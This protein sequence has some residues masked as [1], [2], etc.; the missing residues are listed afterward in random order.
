MDVL[1]TAG[2]LSYVL[3]SGA[4]NVSDPGHVA[5]NDY[6]ASTNNVHWRQIA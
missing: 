2:V 1:F 3:T 5:P 6:N 4:A